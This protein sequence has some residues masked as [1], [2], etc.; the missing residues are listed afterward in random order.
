[1]K[2]LLTL[3][4]GLLPL[5]P[6][7]AEERIISLGSAV[8]EMLYAID[9]GERLVG[10]DSSSTYPQQTQALPRV[11]YHRQL[12]AEGLLSLRPTLILGTTQAGPPETF[13][14]LRQA[15]VE[16]VLLEAPHSLEQALALLQQVAD[17]RGK[18]AQGRAITARIREQIAAARRQAPE[19]APRVLAVLAGQGS[20]L[21]A[22]TDSA[23]DLMI[24][25]AGGVNAGGGFSGYKPLS[26]E[27]L[28][29]LRPEVLLVPSHILPLS[30]GLDTLLAQAGLA[31]TPAAAERRIV[32]MDSAQL[33][34]LGPRLGE[35]LQELAARLRTPA[36]P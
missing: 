13:T 8:T 14:R 20:L 31:Q 17:L 29:G 27:S 36:R 4:L 21:A 22:G 33:L 34:G 2:S 10:V 23:A 9:D 16:V 30:G 19:P 12:G 15:G 3:L 6:A 26:A 11:G 32:V 5:G 35:A 1:M 28:L 7:C 18:P 24:R 25:A